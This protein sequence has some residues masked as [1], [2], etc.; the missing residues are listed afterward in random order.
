MKM[1]EVFFISDLHFGHKKIIEFGKVTG[2]AYRSGDNWQENM[3]NIVVN[4]NRV[5]GKRDKVFVLG[6]VAFNQEGFDALNELNGTKT[7]IRGNHD[8]YF[9]T[10]D[11]LKVFD[12]VEGLYRYKEF[13]LSHAPIHPL[14]LRGK[15][16]IH[17]HVHQH[18]IRNTYTNEYDPNYICVCCEPL[19]E[20]PISLKQIRDGTYDRIRKC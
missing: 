13:W 2:T 8:N 6:D 12:S 1:S 9:K 15:K 19:G 3:H 14:E 18:S 16:N 11:W 4:W 20:T 7:L 10:D 5:V 17:G